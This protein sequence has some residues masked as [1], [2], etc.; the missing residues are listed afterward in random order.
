MG[1]EANGEYLQAPHGVREW[2]FIFVLCATQLFTQGALGYIIIPL[3]E[4]SQTF[5][6]AGHE[7]AAE[8]NWH[9]AGYSLTIGSF[10]L[11]TGRLGDMYG[12]K[13]VFL[14]G[15]AWFGVWSIICGCSALTGSAIFFDVSRAFQGIG[16]ALLIPNALAIAGRTYPPGAKKNLVFCLIAMSA[17]LGCVIGGL[18]GAPLA[19]FVW[20]PW[21]AWISG[22]GCFVVGFAAYVVIPQRR[23]VAEEDE[24]IG[25]DWLGSV[26]G[27]GGLILLNVSWNQA[28]IDGW[29]TPYVYVLLVLGFLLLGLF[30]WQEKRA[31]QPITD[32]SIFNSRVVGVLFTTALGWSSFGIWF[33][34]MFQFLQNLRGISSLESALQ[35]GPGAV[36]GM[37]APFFT[38]WA[39]PRMSSSSLMVLASCAFFLGALLQALA[40]V[41]Q[42]YWYNTFWSFVV[43]PWG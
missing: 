43:M 36:S 38:A 31:A 29:S 9:V 35:F 20:W 33:Y 37:I 32:I 10:I 1:S 4:V 24:R 5:G 11:V 30:F 25:F 17:P 15:W 2:L 12:S 22:I 23:I 39:I 40:P 27:V 42:S 34:Y 16:P 19:Q 7:H 14:V 6:Q 26:L 13:T 41:G 3:R 28:P 21:T 18:I 8:V